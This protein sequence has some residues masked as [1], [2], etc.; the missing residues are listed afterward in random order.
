MMKN[1]LF[2]HKSFFKGV[3]DVATWT[4]ITLLA[5][6]LRLDGDL[7]G[8][9]T[10]AFQ[11][12][13]ILFIVKAALIYYM[14]SYRQSWRNTGFNDVFH[15]VAM[16]SILTVPYTMIV[17]LGNS[18]VNVPLSIPIIE[19]FL[20][21][22]ALTS[23]R[24]G[25]R[26]FI[27]YRIPRIKN[28]GETRRILIAGAGESGMMVAKEMLKNKDAQMQPVAF[29]DDDLSKRNQKL[30]GIPV[31]GTVF[32]IPNIVRRLNIDEIII[33]MPSESGEVIRRVVEKSRQ[34]NA[35]Y[36]II[37]PLYDLLSGKVSISQIRNV[38]VEDLLRRKPIQLETQEIRSYIEGKRVLVTGAGGSIGSE[39]VRQISRFNP[40]H[41]ILLGRGENSIHQ[42]V[43]EIDNEIPELDYCIR[44]CDVRDL[45]T[46]DKIFENEQPEVVFHAAAHKHVPLMEE[47]PSQAIFNNVMGTRNLVNLSVEHHVSH[48]VNI[49]TDKA[50]NPTSVMGA[51]KRIAEHIV[52]WGSSQA[53]NGEI[54]VSVR[55]GNVLGSR[56]SVIP[57]FKDQIRKGGPVTVTHPDM[58][59]YFMT[60]PEASQLVLQAGAL[61]NNGA[62][63]VLDMGDPVNIEQMA[64]D[65]IKLSGFEPDL[66]VKIE[67]T[68]IRPGEKLY[69]ELLTAEEGTDMTRHEKIFM[70]RKHG[71]LDNLEQR[72]NELKKVAETGKK[73]L[74]K[75]AIYNFVPTYSGFKNGVNKKME[76]AE[77]M[78]A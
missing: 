67:H 6:L 20:S 58:V 30:L 22:L 78:L 29:V 4:G 71:V 59:R 1:K 46:L 44:I 52:E 68:G 76:E 12:T 39:I 40:K 19:F 13:G 25:T 27:K 17:L 77:D 62:V 75:E 41:V 74:I 48:F 16:V 63:Y 33:A 10:T 72:L 26:F 73:E 11:A 37:P 51:S 56:G 66:D 2:E 61:N 64:R 70:A 5:F 49:S 55:F 8:Y 45:T 69:E 34:T 18:V 42:L 28:N 21:I 60:I 14:G 57:I 9:L 36:R 38:D 53:N 31:K 43:R 32:D 24:A 50:V 65:L 7:G 23:L 54:F 47:N 3:A 15:I 35:S